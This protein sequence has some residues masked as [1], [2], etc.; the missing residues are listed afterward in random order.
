[1]ELSFEYLYLIGPILFWTFVA[2]R[3]YEVNIFSEI[4]KHRV[5]FSIGITLSCLHLILLIIYGRDW[6]CADT[7]RDRGL[8][9]AFLFPGLGYAFIALPFAVNGSVFENLTEKFAERITSLLGYMFIF[10]G[11]I[12]ILTFKLS[13]IR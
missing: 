13:Q 1:M 6:F 7:L 9:S 5:S 8:D 2:A 10:Y 11:Y 4:K 12:S 3:E